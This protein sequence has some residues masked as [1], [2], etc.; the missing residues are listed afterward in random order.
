MKTDPRQNGGFFNGGKY[1]EIRKSRRPWDPFPGAFPMPGPFTRRRSETPPTG[2]ASPPGIQK[3]GDHT[4]V[5]LCR[6]AVGPLEA[7]HGAERVRGIN[8]LGT[9]ENGP[10]GC[11]GAVV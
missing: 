11:C 9:Q 3:T 4:P 2:A 7:L 8:T 10:G 6:F 5:F 1:N